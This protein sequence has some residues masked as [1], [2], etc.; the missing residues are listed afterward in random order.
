MFYRLTFGI[1]STCPRLG[2]SQSRRHRPEDRFQHHGQ[3][4]LLLRS[5]A[6]SPRQHGHAASAGGQ[7]R[8]VHV[9][10]RKGREQDRLHLDDAGTYEGHNKS[11]L[12][13]AAGCLAVERAILI[14]SARSR[15]SA[16]GAG[17]GRGEGSTGEFAAAARSMA[18]LAFSDPWF[19]TPVRHC[20]TVC[21]WLAA[22]GAHLGAR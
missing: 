17:A 14:R 20:C 22:P 19:I 10:G 21:A 15:H 5:G 16:A 8:R 12:L 13:R 7:R 3:R 6:H 9:Y 2:T 18:G 11:A 4:F 1:S